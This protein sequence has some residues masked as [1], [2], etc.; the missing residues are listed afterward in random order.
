MKV[1][2]ARTN[3][4]CHTQPRNFRLAGKK[5]GHPAGMQKINLGKVKRNKSKTA[6]I[7]IDKMGIR[8]IA[9]EWKLVVWASMA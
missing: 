1:S 9:V 5:F 7:S 3:A 4:L 2:I 8:E 6:K